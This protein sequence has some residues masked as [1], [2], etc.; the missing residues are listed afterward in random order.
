MMINVRPAPGDRFS[1]GPATVVAR[2]TVTNPPSFGTVDWDA[3]VQ[4]QQR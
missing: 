1:D 2:A 4:L 3:E